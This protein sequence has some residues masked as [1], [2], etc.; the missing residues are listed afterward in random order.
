[1]STVQDTRNIIIRFYYS[2]SKAISWYKCHYKIQSFIKSTPFSLRFHRGQPKRNSIS[3]IDSSFLHTTNWSKLN[4]K[5]TTITQKKFHNKIFTLLSEETKITLKIPSF[6]SLS[7]SQ[8]TS[9]HTIFFPA[10]IWAP[11]TI[12]STECEKTYPLS[13]NFLDEVFT[14]YRP[15]ARDG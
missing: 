6:S 7:S 15:R 10:Q 13:K 9:H 1:M 5:I 4:E 3:W 12:P 11:N 2:R 14:S 8:W